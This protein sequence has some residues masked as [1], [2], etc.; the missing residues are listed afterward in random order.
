MAD[1]TRKF[2]G[3]SAETYRMMTEYEEAVSAIVASGECPTEG[4][5]VG[6]ISGARCQSRHNHTPTDCLEEAQEYLGKG[7][8]RR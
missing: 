1:S 4:C 7:T 6:K 3:P 2:I 8:E 5:P